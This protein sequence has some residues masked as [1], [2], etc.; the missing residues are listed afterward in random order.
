MREYLRNPHPG[1]GCQRAR[2]FDLVHKSADGVG[3]LARAGVPTAEWRR[4][5]K[6]TSLRSTLK[7][8]ANSTLVGPI[9]RGGVFDD[10]KK[11]RIIRRIQK[12]RHVGGNIL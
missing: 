1:S 4:A 11:R 12:N 6:S 5:S 2:I 3:R 10:A 7:A 9:P 8:R